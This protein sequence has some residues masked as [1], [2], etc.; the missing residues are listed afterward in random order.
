MIKKISIEIIE[1][2]RGCVLLLCLKN[3]AS[4]KGGTNYTVKKKLTNERPVYTVI[5]QW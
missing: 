4:K 5:E 1:R 3:K 2:E